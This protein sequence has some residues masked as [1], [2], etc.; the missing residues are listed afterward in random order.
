MSLDYLR[1]LAVFMIVY[2]H[3]G[4]FRNSEWS[5]KGI[6]DY[7]FAIPLGIIQEFGAFGVCIFFLISGFLFAWN[8]RYENLIRKTLSRILKIYISSIFA[9]LGFWVF[10]K[11]VWIFG[12]SYWSQFTTVQWIES[13]TLFGYL[14]GHGDM[15]NGTTWF[16]IPFFV[17]YL[18]G[19][20]YG[21]AEKRKHGSGMLVTE[22][23]LAVIFT[24]LYFL[25][26][27]MA[28]NL[29]FVYIP[30]SGAILAELLKARNN[31]DKKNFWRTLL[32]LFVNYLQMIV[33]FNKLNYRY[34]QAELYLVSYMYAILLL[35]VCVIF[36]KMFAETAVCKWICKVSLSVYLVHMTW[37][38]YLMQIFA[39]DMGMSFSFSFILVVTI[40]FALGWIHYR[41]FEEGIIK[42]IERVFHQPKS[43]VAEKKE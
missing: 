38:S 39:V 6:V 10:Q 5:V 30:V 27:D 1:V 7:L 32:V 11:L 28:A 14:N 34:Y 42:M 22:V 12:P 24:A 21:T 2:D 16:L 40:I 33:A 41:L 25:R 8:G 23:I 35:A 37:G 20:A 4:A 29:T 17:F 15:V 43:I 19:A 26:S 31:G 18:V 36:E 9:L 3:L 13:L